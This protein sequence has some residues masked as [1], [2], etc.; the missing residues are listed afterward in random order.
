MPIHDL[1]IM[2]IVICITFCADVSNNVFFISRWNKV[3]SSELS[4]LGLNLFQDSSSGGFKKFIV[5]LWTT[6]FMKVIA[7][8]CWIAYPDYNLICLVDWIVIDN[9]NS[10]IGFWIWVQL[11]HF[12]PNPKKS[13]F[14][15]SKFVFM[16]HH[17]FIKK[18]KIF[19]NKTFVWY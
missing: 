2:I 16:M 5:I 7:E 19:N 14:L 13:S 8:Y 4:K 10:K 3:L 9:L 15:F 18:N 6:L 1:H 12:N 11:F 17:A